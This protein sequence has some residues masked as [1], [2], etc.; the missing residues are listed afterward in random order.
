MLGHTLNKKDGIKMINYEDIEKEIKRLA[1]NEKQE[2][3]AMKLLNESKPKIKNIIS[4]FVYNKD[5]GKELV[6]LTTPDI[7]LRFKFEKK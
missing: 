1:Y 2:Q 5:F 6:L 3:E 4:R 7:N